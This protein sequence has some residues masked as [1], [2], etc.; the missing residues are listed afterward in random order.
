MGTTPKGYKG[1]EKRAR[2]DRCLV[3]L[4][5]SMDNISYTE[6]LKYAR[7]D[8]YEIPKNGEILSLLADRYILESRARSGTFKQAPSRQ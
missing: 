1:P 5:L 6:A 8:I 4:Y 2:F 3:D 7:R